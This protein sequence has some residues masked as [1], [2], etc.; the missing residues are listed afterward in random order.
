MDETRTAARL[1]GK[2]A[3]KIASSL[4]LSAPSSEL[5][6]ILMRQNLKQR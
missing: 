1:K 6:V 3:Q 2:S 4:Q 5:R